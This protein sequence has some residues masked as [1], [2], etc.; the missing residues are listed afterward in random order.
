MWN[1]SSVQ[2][3]VECRGAKIVHCS[4][5]D[6]IQI[7]GTTFVCCPSGTDQLNDRKSENGE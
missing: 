2:F 7:E 1:E 3:P 4:I 6:S 5:L